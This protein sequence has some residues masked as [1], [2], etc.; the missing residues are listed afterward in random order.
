[1]SA[2]QP[3]ADS[4]T[5]QILSRSIT[6]W[7]R[8]SNVWRDLG[9]ELFC[10]IEIYWQFELGRLHNRQFRGLFALQDPAEIDASRQVTGKLVPVTNKATGDKAST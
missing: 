1:M 6:S 4:C 10:R 7:A 8:L 5:A 9:A 3:Q 2:L